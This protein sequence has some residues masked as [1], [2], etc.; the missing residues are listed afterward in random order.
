MPISDPFNIPW[1]VATIQRLQPARVLDVGPGM[2]VYGVL[3]RQYLDIAQERITRSSWRVRIDGIEVYE[4]YRNPIWEYF[5]D[6]VEIADF[7]AT[8]S[9]IESYDVILL[10]DVLEHFTKQEGLIILDQCLDK[11]R[12]VVVTTPRFNFPQGEWGGN[13]NESHLSTWTV[14]NSATYPCYA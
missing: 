2:G 12:F 7:R 8:V 5:Y 1:V 6:R 14:S 3:L 13:P 9:Q 11:A 4:S 10:C